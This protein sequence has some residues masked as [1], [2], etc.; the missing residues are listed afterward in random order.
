M[1]NIKLAI[2]FISTGIVLGFTL[3]VYAHSNFATKQMMN[4]LRLNR[5]RELDKTDSR[6]DRIEHKL[7]ILIQKIK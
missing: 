1:N 4:D 3:I 7:D 5:D 2:Y 6:L